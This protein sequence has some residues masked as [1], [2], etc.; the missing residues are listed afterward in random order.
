VRVRGGGVLTGT[1]SYPVAVAKNSV[2]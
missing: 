2:V 1:E